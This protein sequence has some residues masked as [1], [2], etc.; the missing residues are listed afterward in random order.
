MISFFKKEII[1][2]LSPPRNHYKVF[3]LNL[4]GFQIFRYLSKYIEFKV[5]NKKL[6]KTDNSILDRLNKDGYILLENFLAADEIERIEKFLQKIID[7]KILINKKYGDKDVL[8]FDLLTYNEVQN[9]SEVEEVSNIFYAKIS[10]FGL[11]QIINEKIES[12]PSLS[13]ENITVGDNFNDT[14]DL[15]SEF[16]ADR[17]YPCLK[18]FY[19]LNENK[20]KNG[21]FQYI[22]SSHKY[23]VSRLIHEYIYS[24]LISLPFLKPLAKTFGYVYKNNRFTF[25]EEKISK[26]YGKNSIVSCEGPKNTLVI[27]NNKGF[28]KRGQFQPKQTRLHLRMNFYD[29]QMPNWKLRLKKF[30]KRKVQ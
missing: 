15:N 2:F 4:F 23:A 8:S 26:T 28:H 12:L 17:Y 25:S 13:Y 18:A 6:K 19:Y 10:Q 5:F 1:N 11:E 21:A 20:I 14:G 22:K 16:H 9:D 30:L 3:I 29:L 27:C 7:K 24:I